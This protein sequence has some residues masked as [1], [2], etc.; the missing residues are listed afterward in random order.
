MPPT[1]TGEAADAEAGRAIRRLLRSFRSPDSYGL[2]VVL[3]VVTYGLSIWLSRPWGAP[4][5]VF[6]Q[7]GTVGLALR[8]SRARRHLLVA[9]GVAFVVA[10][11]FAVVSLFTRRDDEPLPAVYL[12]GSLLYLAAPFSILRHIAFRRAVDRETMLGALAGYLLFGMGFAL[13]YRFLAG[14]QENPFFGAQGDGEI[15]D[16][17]FFSFITLTTTGYGN[18]VPAENPGQSMAVLEALL[19][20]LFLVTAVTKLVSAWKPQRW[21][22]EGDPGRDAPGGGAEIGGGQPV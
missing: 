10:A 7:I 16:H 4:T 17:L 21:D 22:T 9:A 11:T 20:Q 2:V 5:V 13:G 15:A 3:I 19:G 14:V 12:I 8:T 6:V 18:V 1:T